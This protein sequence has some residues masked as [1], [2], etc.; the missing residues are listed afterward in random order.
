MEYFI[1]AGGVY[2]WIRTLGGPLLVFMGLNY[3]LSYEKYSMYFGIFCIIFG[4]YYAFRPML[5][6]LLNKEGI[7]NNSSV[8]LFLEETALGCQINKL[9]ITI[10]YQKITEFS[11]RKWYYII[12]ASKNRS[13]FIPSGEIR[14]GWVDAFWELRNSAVN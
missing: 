9:E 3:L 13:I 7:F 11:K 12:K 10:D 1:G 14:Q 4:V 5:M 2:V 6:V 8:I